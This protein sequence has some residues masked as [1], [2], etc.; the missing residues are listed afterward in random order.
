[1]RS[2]WVHFKSAVGGLIDNAVRGSESMGGEK[3]EFGDNNS[4]SDRSPPRNQPRY[5]DE[6]PTSCDS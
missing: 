4:T 3:R 5:Q 2:V 1:M 6:I